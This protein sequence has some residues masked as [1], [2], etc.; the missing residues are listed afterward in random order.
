[1]SIV[2]TGA[3]GQLAKAVIDQALETI[4]VTDLILVTRSPGDLEGYAARGA[5]VRY[6]DFEEL[7]SLPAAFDNGRRM[8]LISTD[9]VGDRVDQHAAAIDAA[10]K[11]GVEMIAYTSMINPVPENPAFVIPDH[12]ATEQKLLD[13]GLAWVFL[14][15]SMYAEFQESSMTA[16]A[17]SGTLVT[18]TGSGAVAY[19]SRED[20][21]AAATAVLV[22]D[23]H[24]GNAYDITGPEL[25]DAAK[26]AEIFADITGKTIEVVQ[27]DDDTFAQGLADAT[28]MPI[29]ATRGMASFGQAAREGYLAVVSADFANLTGRKAK[30]LRSVLSR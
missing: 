10:V 7:E 23:G 6:G 2:I 5:T 11:A 16:A 26:R 29:S 30:D 19:V 14:R 15:N 18:N 28:G 8:L 4:D 27:V 3:S 20:C 13:S 12:R 25:I 1:V 21:A 17:S 24:A 22:A 9:A